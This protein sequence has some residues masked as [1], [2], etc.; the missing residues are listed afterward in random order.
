MFLILYGSFRFF[1][2]F[3]REPDKQI[4]FEFLHMTRGQEFCLGMIA[5]GVFFFVWMKK[6]WKPYPTGEGLVVPSEPPLFPPG[7]VLSE[8]LSAPGPLAGRGNAARQ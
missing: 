3:F 6:T 8:P 5:L 2:E 4:G 7:P 1:T